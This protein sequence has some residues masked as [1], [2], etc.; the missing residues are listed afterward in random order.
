MKTGYTKEA[1]YCLTAT[2]KRNNMRVI[3]VVMG[4]PE[5]TTRTTDVSAMLDY[6]FAQYDV[7]SFLSTDS[8]IDTVYV[9]KGKREYIDIVPKDNVTILNK[10]VDNKKNVTYDLKLDNLKLPIK[11]G[12]S[13]GK[14]LCL[15]VPA[16]IL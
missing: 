13:V 8:V 5:S 2:A 12:D 10:K 11:K 9:N 1:G 7:E 4:E 15:L 3:A 16:P 14:L 6:A